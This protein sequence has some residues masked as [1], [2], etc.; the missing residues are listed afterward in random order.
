[1]TQPLHPSDPAAGADPDLRAQAQHW[2]ARL[3][4]GAIAEGEIDQLEGWLAASPDHARAF[5]RERALWQDLQAAFAEPASASTHAIPPLRSPLRRRFLPSALPS[6]KRLL[7][8][9]PMAAAASIAVLAAPSIMLGLRADHRTATGEVRRLALPDG[10]TAML[11]S[12][13]AISV[14]FS[15]GQRVVHLL[16]GRAWFD[17]NHETRPFMVTAMGGTTRDIGTGFEVDQGR[18]AVSISVTEGSVQ[19]RAPDGRQTAPLQ[20]GERVRYSASG[21]D[22]LVPLSASQLAAWRNGEILLEHQSIESA[23]ADIARY[24]RAPV[25]TL[26]DFGTAAP[27]SGLFLIERPDEALQTIARMRGLRIITL[28]GGAMLIRPIANP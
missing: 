28:P 16:A 21:I 10:T 7:Q 25:W 27:V 11:D 24:R 14:D 1:M 18:D 17:V 26:G 4:S 12:A 9:V 13:S 2:V 15:H 23:I 19:V 3:A 20:T 22:R 6:G 8:L 5:S